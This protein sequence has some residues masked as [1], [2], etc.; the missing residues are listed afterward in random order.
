[1][2]KRKFNGGNSTKA[3]PGKIDK[4]RNEYK[5]ALQEASTVEDVVKVINMI[6][7]KAINEKD[8]NAAKLF[9]SYYLGNPK[10]SVDITTNGK[11]IN[12]DLDYSNLSDKALKEIANLSKQD[13]PE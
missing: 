13:K 10:D 1:M 7:N 3:K 6:K 9:L 8:T 5:Q 11:D 12:S 2:D 4:R